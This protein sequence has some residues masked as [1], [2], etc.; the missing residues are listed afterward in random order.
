MRKYAY[1]VCSVIASLALFSCAKE[2]T[3]ITIP[4][5][6]VYFKIDV[7]SDKIGFF[8]YAVF[9]KPRLMGEFTGYSGLLIFR[10]QD[11]TIFAYDLCCPHEKNKD[12]KVE[13]NNV[14]EAICPVCGSKYDIW[15]GL[16]NV[17]SGQA[18][19]PLQTYRVVP[20]SE[21]VFRIQN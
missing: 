11:G 4:Y 13:A 12:V 18:R 20:I 8:D 7:V 10:N 14:G 5:A 19:Q 9:E 16:G 15:T 1:I 6:P 21:G 2:Q 17:K 3:H